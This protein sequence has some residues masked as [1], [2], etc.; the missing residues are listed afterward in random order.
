MDSGVDT[1]VKGDRTA[2]SERTA[3]TTTKKKTLSSRE[4]GY[5]PITMALL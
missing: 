2:G 1:T 5:L 3:P 4:L